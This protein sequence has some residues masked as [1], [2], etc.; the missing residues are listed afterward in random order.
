MAAAALLALT[1]GLPVL[2]AS[3]SVPDED[4]LDERRIEA[5]ADDLGGPGN[6]PIAEWIVRE[7][8]R[9]ERAARITRSES[10]RGPGVLQ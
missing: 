2:A 7:E 1:V 8:T 9:A 6:R 3:S 10:L 5:V 4:R